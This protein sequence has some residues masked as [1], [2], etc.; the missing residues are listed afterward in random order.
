MLSKPCAVSSCGSNSAAVDL[1]HKQIA[2]RVFVFLAIQPMQHH[3][4]GDV[5]LAGNLVERI[6]EPRDQRVDS[7]CR[8]A[9][10]RP[11]AA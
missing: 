2:N 10:S 5:R 7:L 11:E 3:L 1:D 8:P 4:I 9:A 6:L